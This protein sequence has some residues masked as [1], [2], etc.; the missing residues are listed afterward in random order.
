MLIF[1]RAFHFQYAIIIQSQTKV[2]LSLSEL[3]ELELTTIFNSPHKLAIIRQ[4]E[5]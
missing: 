5:L 3:L 4:K 2:T 1:F